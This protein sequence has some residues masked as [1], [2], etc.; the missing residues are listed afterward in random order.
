MGD[1]NYKILKSFGF[2]KKSDK[3]IFGL[4][5][6]HISWGIDE[7]K[8]LRSAK[9]FFAVGQFA[10]GYFVIAQFGLAFVFGFG[11]FILAPIS[12]AQFSFGIVAIGQLS[13]GLFSIGQFAF[14]LLAIGL[15][16][17]GKYLFTPER[18]DQ[19][20]LEILKK[21]LEFFKLLIKF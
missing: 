1:Q 2:D 19:Q 12:I 6:Y 17:F 3:I 7:N 16:A 21:I 11:Q 4:P 20:V 5:L 15:T 13:F 18:Q 14:G 8:K 9:G 10:T